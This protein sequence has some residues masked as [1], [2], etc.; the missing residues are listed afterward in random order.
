MGTHHVAFDGSLGSEQGEFGRDWY[1]DIP[2]GQHG[3]LLSSKKV[4]PTTYHRNK[5]C[6]DLQLARYETKRLLVWNYTL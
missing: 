3:D 2:R 6:A 5:R 1:L 4:D